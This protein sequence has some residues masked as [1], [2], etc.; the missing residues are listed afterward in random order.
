ML[1][2]VFGTHLGLDDT[3]VLELGLA[4]MLHDL[5][6]AMVPRQVLEKSASLSVAE[7]AKVKGHC[8]HGMSILHDRRGASKR[9]KQAVVEHHERYDGSGYPLGLSGSAISPFARYIALADCY[10]AMTSKR[11]Y[12]DAMLPSR[13]LSLM[14]QQR[15]SQFAPYDVEQ[16]IKCIGVYPTGSLVRLTDG[17][18]AVVFETNP[19]LP[20]SPIVNVVMDKRLQPV[21]PRMVNLAT[22]ATEDGL[23]EI[24]SSLCPDMLGVDMSRLL[25]TSMNG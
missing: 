24:A 4:G 5:G 14:Y 21:L 25:A 16:F 15:G 1:C 22:E 19:D 10:D 12:K 20:L 9:L 18:T 6:K 8:L 23:I 13:V 3:D 17:R 7:F 11:T 2:V